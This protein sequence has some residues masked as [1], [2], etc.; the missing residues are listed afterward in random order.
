MVVWKIILK[1]KLKIFKSP[2]APAFSVLNA[3]DE[4]LLEFSKECD[5]TVFLFDW[6]NWR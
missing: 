5:G 2:Q 3:K 4:R 1:Q 6:R